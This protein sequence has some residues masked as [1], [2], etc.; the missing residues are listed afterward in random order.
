M[1]ASPK[2]TAF[3]KECMADS[4]LGLL[5]TRPLSKI[6]VTEIAVSAG[7]N[8]S[9]WFRHFETKNEA[10][11]YKLV[12]LGTRWAEEHGLSTLKQYTPDHADMFFAFAYSIRD[13]L[14][15]IHRAGLQSCLFDAYRQVIFPQY[16]SDPGDRYGT[17]FY[18][19]G[20]MGLLE[21][22]IRRDFL[23]TPEQMTAY[24]KE[25][26]LGKRTK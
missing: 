8:R 23:E 16:G 26:M 10:I 21:E 14:K 9:T 2:T 7:V 13:T 3:L 11:V 19:C 12:L 24:F 17:V 6:T 20:L 15:T 4:L 22:W 1:G 5:K 25:I 18:A